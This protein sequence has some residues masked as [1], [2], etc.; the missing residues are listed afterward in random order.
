M[1]GRQVKGRNVSDRSESAQTKL[2]WRVAFSF[3]THNSLTHSEIDS[4]ESRF[5]QDRV[6]HPH[7]L[8]NTI[9]KPST[10]LFTFRT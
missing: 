2:S 8:L 3:G 4:G 9:P 6:A 5:C 7:A 10:R 1:M